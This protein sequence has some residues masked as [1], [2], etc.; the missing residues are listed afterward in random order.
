MQ[1]CK[2]CEAIL[3]PGANFCHKCG[4]PVKEAEENA[5][6]IRN[7]EAMQTSLFE[8][9]EEN[10]SEPILSEISTK[11][12][13]NFDADSTIELEMEQQSSTP[14]EATHK[15]ELDMTSYKVL[16][17][18]ALRNRVEEEHNPLLYSDYVER[19][20]R[21]DFQKFMHSSLDLWQVE[22]QRM[23]TKQIEE[24][25]IAA[26]Q[27]KWLSKWLNYF[28]IKECA[29]LN[30]VRLNEKILIY[31]ELLLSDINLDLMFEDFLQL[32]FEKSVK[33][34]KN[35][36]TMPSEKLEAAIKSFASV[37]RTERIL[38]IA[39]SSITGTCKEGFA[40][41][42]EALYW[43]AP[44]EKAQR[45]EF[46]A[47]SSVVRHKDWIEINGLF[48][49]IGKNLNMKLLRLLKTLIQLNKNDE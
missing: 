46:S 42:N 25:Y 37:P 18:E 1:R 8:E 38:F 27:E 22:M 9:S 3:L 12:F 32:N 33:I 11:D 2:K 35:F 49:N 31:D 29:D 26:L 45:V 36:F 47:L 24:N 21:S 48:F 41:S 10:T 30:E 6:I 13:Y 20:Y 28:I 4:Y 17:F 34:Y 14:N 7:E 15:V 40:M 16:F 23:K 19:F 44:L 5:A 39:D 43:K